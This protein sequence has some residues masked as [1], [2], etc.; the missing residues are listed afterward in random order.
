M[1]RPAARLVLGWLLLG[2]AAALLVANLFGSL[3]GGMSW[4]AGCGVILL[5]VAGLAL[6]AGR[7]P[8]LARR[9]P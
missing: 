4:P 3:L 7:D 9:E 5:A 8:R 2:V 6:I 1:P